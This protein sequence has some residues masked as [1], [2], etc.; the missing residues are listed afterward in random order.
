MI[1]KVAKSLFDL[2]QATMKKYGSISNKII[3]G[4]NDITWEDDICGPNTITYLKESWMEKARAAIEAM[5]EP[6]AK[7]VRAGYKSETCMPDESY[8]IMIDVALKE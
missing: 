3:F 6:T 2:D 1:E 5:R 7:M 8:K 4:K